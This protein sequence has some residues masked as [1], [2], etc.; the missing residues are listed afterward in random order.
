[1]SNNSKIDFDLFNDYYDKDFTGFIAKSPLNSVNLNERINEDQNSFNINI[2]DDFLNMPNGNNN[3]ETMD[4]T[5]P[6]DKYFPHFEINNSQLPN[7][8]IELDIPK[9]KKK[10]NFLNIKK[11]KI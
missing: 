11:V 3:K 4:K 7:I 5:L 2:F 10:K 9:K 6:K 8:R 1:M